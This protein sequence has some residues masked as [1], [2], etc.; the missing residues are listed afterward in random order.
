MVKSPRIVDEGMQVR[1]HRSQ[2]LPHFSLLGQQLL[3]H[4]EH[5]TPV[6]DRTLFNQAEE[7]GR[8]DLRV[9]VEGEKALF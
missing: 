1:L 9:L 7:L 6:A 3:G 4:H 2:P 8:A 5:F